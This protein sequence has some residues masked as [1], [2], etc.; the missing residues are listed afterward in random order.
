MSAK[1][2]RWI[3]RYGTSAAALS[4]GLLCLSA[5]RPAGAVTDFNPFATVDVSHSSNI[6]QLPDKQALSPGASYEDTVTRAI[7]GLLADFDWGPEKLALNAQG[8]RLQYAQNDDLSHFESMFGGKFDWLA[9]PVFSSTLNY[10]QARTITAP[11][12]TLS[13]D[14]EVQTDHVAGGSFRFLVTPRV[15]IDLE[16]GWHQLD[17]PLQLYPDFG[18]RETSAA[19]SLLYMGM[20]KLWSGLR[21]RY[22]DGSYHHI[23]GATRYNQKTA[24]L[25]STYAVTNLTSFDFRAGY[26][27]RNTS[28]VNP[29]DATNPALGGL[30]GDLGSTSG[31]TGAIGL[32]RRLTVK[33][34]VNVRAFREVS[35][36]G[37]GANSYVSTGAEGGVN[38]APD[39]R[40]TIG[41]NYR[42]AREDIDGLQAITGFAGRSDRINTSELSVQYHAL[43]WLSLRPYASRYTRSSNLA[44][45]SYNATIVGIDF[46]A[47]LHP[48]K[49]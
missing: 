5:S 22:V 4:A 37:A 28:L 6:F 11:G 39:F 38:W 24:E 8:S 25:T 17:S 14:L 48:I 31:F 19:G 10:S 7:A 36:Y 47:R 49:Q 20:A 2:T 26:T 15:R 33:T 23:V 1:K 21:F 35:S 29:A 13:Q 12:A 27:W 3:I 30:P 9:G 43:D 41:A 16:P 42:Y 46:T 45:A 44:R 32:T 34:S 40:F 18:Y